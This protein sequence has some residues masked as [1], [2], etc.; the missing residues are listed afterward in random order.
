M[1]FYVLNKYTD[2]KSTPNKEIK[3]DVREEKNAIL[4]D[5][6]ADLFACGCQHEQK[7]L[8]GERKDRP[9]LLR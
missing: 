4:S 3:I 8:V 6:T 1:D 9:N 5:T 7:G 2:M